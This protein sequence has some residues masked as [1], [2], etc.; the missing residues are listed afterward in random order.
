MPC[1]ICGG[2][3]VADERYPNTSFVRCRECGF[4]FNPTESAEQLKDHYT[5][6][7]FEDY[8]DTAE[9][10]SDERQRGIEAERRLAWLSEWAPPPGRLLEVGAAA[11]FFLAAARSA[12]YEVMGIEPGVAVSRYARER[13][14]LDVRNEF[15]EDAELPESHFDLICMFH[16]FEHIHDPHHV[17][18]LLRRSSAGGGF[19]AIE[20]PNLWSA[21][22]RHHGERWFALDAHN[23]VGFYA[24][25]HLR[26]IFAETGFELLEAH[27]VSEYEYFGAR[28]RLRPRT[29]AARTFKRTIVWRSQ[30]RRDAIAHTHLR[31]IAR[32]V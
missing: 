4:V 12:G 24:P 21:Q 31:A 15:L 3:A 30:T 8:G 23:H 18:R 20:I 25:E 7:Y 26:R 13:F 22:A 29:V 14:E 6:D 2:E 16:V 17:L 28:D 5:D 1:W 10:E 32:A 27:T 11:G 19:L 9:Y